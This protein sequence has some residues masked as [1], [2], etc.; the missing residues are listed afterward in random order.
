[1]TR[2][3]NKITFN[4]QTETIAVSGDV[5][6][7][8][9]KNIKPKINVSVVE[10][11]INTEKY[12]RNSEDGMRIRSEYN[13]P[14]N[15]VV[16]GNIAVFR[17]QKRLKEWIEV[18]ASSSKSNPNLFGLLVG[19]GPFMEQVQESIEA[20]GLK[21]KIILAGLQ[22]DVKPYYSAI[23]IFMMTSL[24]EGLPIALLEAMSMECAVV[25]TNA[26]GT[27][28]VIRNGEDGFLVNVSEWKDLSALIDKLVSTPLLIQQYGIKARKRVLES[29]GLNKTVLAFEEMYLRSLKN[30]DAT[31]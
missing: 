23:D 26:G 2:F 31:K 4:Y 6:N 3:F 28:S 29:Y 11:G 12:V 16:V 21:N 14:Q 15:A 9:D 18:F 8:I 30:Y 10:N 17:S 13:I 1:M 27:K 20:H 25:C 19:Q 7:S 24:Y 22:S 5:K